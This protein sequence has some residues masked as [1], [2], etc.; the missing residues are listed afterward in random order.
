MS[1]A[2]ELKEAFRKAQDYFVR[3]GDHLLEVKTPG[4]S[5]PNIYVTYDFLCR[6]A[7]AR[8]GSS[9]SG[10]NVMRFC[11]LDRDV[12]EAMHAQLVRLGGKPPSLPPAASENDGLKKIASASPRVDL[13]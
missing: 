8:T 12:L 5:G 10:V 7:Y 13:G 1:G 6:M 11:D 2:E 3:V 9:E 4:Y